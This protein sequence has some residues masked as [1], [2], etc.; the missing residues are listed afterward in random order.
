MKIPL[1]VSS[2]RM[3]R[4]NRETSRIPTTIKERSTSLKKARRSGGLLAGP[5]VRSQIS[6]NIT[7]ALTFTHM[8]HCQPDALSNL[9]PKLHRL[10][11]NTLLSLY[12][13]HGD[14]LR[15][16]VRNSVFPAISVNFPPDGLDGHRSVVCEPH[17]DSGNLADGFCWVLA[18]GD[19]DSKKGGHLVLHE[20]N[21]VIEFP[22]G[23]SIFF[24]SSV[25][26]HS[27]TA[28]SGGESRWSITQF[29]AGGL[30]RW[31]E[32]GYHT[33]KM[34]EKKHKRIAARIKDDRPHLWRAG[35]GLFSSVSSLAKDRD[36]MRRVCTAVAARL[37]VS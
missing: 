5:R 8:L 33:M 13:V 6:L 4:R 3:L 35:L 31:V 11:A 26:S 2:N 28:V 36:E 20:L 9:A 34:L 27:N 24:P 7:L 30:F 37:K 17:K 18:G 1:L 12:M 22:A 23:A 14:E 10:Y 32:Y 25:I 21:L 29:A 19:F 15:R 16:P